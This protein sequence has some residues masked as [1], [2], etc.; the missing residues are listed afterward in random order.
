MSRSS[1]K[2]INK[3]YHTHMKAVAKGSHEKEILDSLTNGKNN[4]LRMDRT[5][6]SSFDNTWIDM[7]EGVIFD[8]GEIVQNPR[9][10]TRTEGNLVPVELARKTNADSVQHLASHTQYIKEIDEMGNVVPSKI[11]SIMHDDDIKTYENRFI[12]TLIRRLVLFVEKRYEIV[13]ELAELCDEEILM[14]KNESEIDGAIVEVETKVKISRKNDSAQSIQTNSYIERIKK[15]RTYL[16]YFYRSEFMN[17]LRTEKD[18]HNPI[19]QTNIIRKNPKY[20]H[21]YE[22]FRFIEGYDRV[23]VNYKVNEKYSVFTEEEMKEL[24]RTIFANYITLKGKDNSK[25]TK[26][27]TKVYKPRILTSLDDE[28]FIYGPLLSGPIEFVRSDAFYREYQQSKLRD[29][30]PQHPTKQEKE[31]YAD[32]YAL[33]DEFRQDEKQLDDLVKRVENE[34]K[35]FDKDAEKVDSE[36]EEDRLDLIRREKEVIKAEEDDMLEE[37]REELIASALRDQSK[38]PVGEQAPEEQ[39]N[40]DDIQPAVI[41]VEM[42][43]PYQEPVTFE[44]AVQEI[45]PQINNVPEPQPY[46]ENPE[47]PVEEEKPQESFKP[48]EPVTFEQAVQEIWPQIN[49]KPEPE[50]EETAPVYVEQ[51]AEQPQ[52]EPQQEP[53]PVP[54]PVVAPAPAPIQK[55]EKPKRQHVTYKTPE[56]TYYAV[57]T[58]KGYY[59]GDDK[60]APTMSQAKLFKDYNEARAT[61]RKVGGKILMAKALNQ[62]PAKPEPPKPEPKPR[63]KIPGKF[64]LLTDQGYYISKTKFTNKMSE[65]RIF[66]DFRYANGIRK[67][68]GGKVIKL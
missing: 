14:I 9:L 20:H 22:V 19:L 10:N 8:L 35:K 42:S 37:A 13:A 27:S 6:S 54:V 50:P 21:C 60:R 46:E 58:D 30:L 39:E 23:G 25:E 66:D 3:R 24:N 38:R 47:Y 63:T 59:A 29:D 40:Y 28:S 61:K 53:Q 16:L 64:I 49:N 55:E 51:P 4:Y 52:E 48:G 36:R 57:L 5:Q 67:L 43:H 26:V 62:Q 68:R 12:A 41:P 31:Y 18:V 34:A 17:Q 2:Q 15:M 33:K 1:L 56:G 7:I 32:E 45:W 44:E 65:A 11:L